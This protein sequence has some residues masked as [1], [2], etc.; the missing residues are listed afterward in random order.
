MTLHWLPHNLCEYMWILWVPGRCIL[1]QLIELDFSTRH[2]LGPNSLRGPDTV[3][4][5][6][7]FLLDLFSLWCL[8]FE[9]QP[10]FMNRVSAHWGPW[11]WGASGYRTVFLKADGIDMYRLFSNKALQS[12]ILKGYFDT[13]HHCCHRHHR[14]RHPPPHHHHHHHHHLLLQSWMPLKF[15]HNVSPMFRFWFAQSKNRGVSLNN[16]FYIFI[17][18]YYLLTP[19]TPKDQQSRGEFKSQDDIFDL[20]HPQKCLP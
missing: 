5:R 11:V 15:H 2:P 17:H 12:H 18:L 20:I 13:I 3:H 1:H 19:L 8:S 6:T 14:H 4:L 16:I 10:L 9:L 7:C